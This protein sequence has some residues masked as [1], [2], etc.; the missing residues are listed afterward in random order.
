MDNHTYIYT[1]LIPYYFRPDS[2]QFPMYAS[3][4][5]PTYTAGLLLLLLVPASD[6]AFE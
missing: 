5:V 6:F 4:V 2:V 1:F 3:L